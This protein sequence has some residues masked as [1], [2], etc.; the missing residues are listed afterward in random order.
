M[1]IMG[2]DPG[3]NGAFV[4]LDSATRQIITK[5]ILPRLNNDLDVREIV[6]TFKTLSVT[7]CF[8][9]QLFL[10]HS[11]PGALQFGTNYGR[12]LA[13]LEVLNIAYYPVSPLTWQKHSGFIRGENTKKQSVLK[14][15]EAFPNEL[16]CTNKG[17]V[18]YDGLTD[19]ALISLYGLDFASKN[20]DLKN[21]I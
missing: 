8:T 10:A 9:E 6:K 3:I 18:A 5:D 14:A 20:D 19:A 16:W 17:K 13:C 21:L 12:L 1:N 2:L 7:L 15:K 11:F 4:L